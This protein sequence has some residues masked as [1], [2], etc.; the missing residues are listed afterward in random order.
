MFRGHAQVKVQGLLPDGQG[1]E[2][3][4]AGQRA[5]AEGQAAAGAGMGHQFVALEDVKVEVGQVGGEDPQQLL[6]LDGRKLVV[7]PQGAAAAGGVEL[8]EFDRGELGEGLLGADLLQLKVGAGIEQHAPLP[9]FGRLGGQQMNQGQYQAGDQ[10][11]G[12]PEPEHGRSPFVGEWP[13][14]RQGL[15]GR[16]M[17]KAAIWPPW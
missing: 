15:L 10:S 12:S 4:T 16:N 5:F 6:V 7:Q 2:E 8:V 13:D 3:I 1:Q 17:T 11:C 9:L 14:Y